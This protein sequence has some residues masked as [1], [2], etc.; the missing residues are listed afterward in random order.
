[1]IESACKWVVQQ[2]FKGV[3]MCWSMKPFYTTKQTSDHIG[4]GLYL[5]NEIVKKCNM[6]I[7]VESIKDE[8]TI[9]RILAA[10]I[11]INT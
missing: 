6:K 10:P 9:V 4:L 7:E 11:N 1:M 3:G 5:V 8:G 2:R